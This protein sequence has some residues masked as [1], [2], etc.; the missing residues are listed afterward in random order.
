MRRNYWVLLVLSLS[1]AAADAGETNG[2]AAIG[3]SIHEAVHAVIGAKIADSNAAMLAALSAPGPSITIDAPAPEVSAAP[4]AGDYT[5]VVRP[6]AKYCT[7]A[8]ANKG[9][10]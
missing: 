10:C 2:N 7:P 1:A 4:P 5:L 3:G 9:D 8:R 6:E